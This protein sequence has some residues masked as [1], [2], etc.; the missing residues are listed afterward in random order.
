MMNH[1]GH[2]RDRTL[3]ILPL[4]GFL[5]LSLYHFDFMLD[6]PFI[7]FRYARNLL[8]GYGLVFNPGE[9]VEGYSNF[10][11][12]IL[13][14]PF[15][16]LGI[17]PVLASKILGLLL[18]GFTIYYTYE[19]ALL[20]FADWPQKYHA[21]FYSSALLGISWYFSLWSVG[22]LETSLFA[23]LILLSVYLFV[24]SERLGGGMDWSFIPLALAGMT[25]PEAPLFYIVLFFVKL[26]LLFRRHRSVRNF[27]IW[28]AGLAGAYGTYFVWRAVYY[29]Q[30]LPNPYYAKTLGGTQQYF[31][32]VRYLLAFLTSQGRIFLVL[33]TLGLFGLLRLLFRN[34]IIRIVALLF[35]G[36]MVFI[37][38][39]GGDWMCGYRFLAQVYPIYAVLFAS[40]LM[41]LAE[42]AALKLRLARHSL[43]IAL[44]LFSLT[45][46]SSLVSSYKNLRQEVPWLGNWFRRLSISPAGPYHDV[47]MYLKY[48]APPGSWVALGEAGIIPYFAD[49]VNV[50][51]IF[52]L[53]DRQIARIPGLLHHKGDAEYVLSR[54]PDYILLLVQEDVA[55]NI[56]YATEPMR[57]FLDSRSFAGK[58]KL[59]F[60]LL[61]GDAGANVDV[62][63]LYQRVGMPDVPR[64]LEALGFWENSN[65]R[66][67]VN[68][69]ELVAGEST[70]HL[71]VTNLNA[72]AIDILYTLDGKAMPIIHSWAL[73]SNHSASLFV[74]SH[75]PK[76]HYVYK[77]IRDSRDDSPTG[78]IRVD[79][80]IVVK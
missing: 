44:F 40:A 33:F 9:R 69:A 67:E 58:Y 55:G 21:A 43:L 73:D 68:P 78:W 41:E 45:I 34:A 6:D 29:A 3:V 36:Y 19:F 75:T 57:Q 2:F 48:S 23:F 8:N 54:N 60:K 49:D 66:L 22:G 65:V 47:A 31:L 7:S 52:G 10:L 12:I 79:V 42:F 51:D 30:L 15:M 13:L 71:H 20:V 14:T 39:S 61:R 27:A 53:M 59:V 25:R 72:P 24:K 5:F 56:R 74:G 17:Y 63:R 38:Y 80:P 37:V 1:S 28:A 77:A 64:N 62:F 18:G 35:S 50:I 16:K 70:L 32:G 26:N 11:W 4:L 46:G 76:G